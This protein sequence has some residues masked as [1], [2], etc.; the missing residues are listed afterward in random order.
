MTN[1][2]NYKSVTIPCIE[3]GRMF[4][5]H[6]EDDVVV[7]S[8]AR[9]AINI[10][11]AVCLDCIDLLLDRVADPPGLII[12]DGLSAIVAREIMKSFTFLLPRSEAAKFFAS[13]FPEVGE[14]ELV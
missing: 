6:I 2:N 12:F 14:A 13:F 5:F 7:G 10:P 9:I 4:E 1:I 8:E 3:C 11:G